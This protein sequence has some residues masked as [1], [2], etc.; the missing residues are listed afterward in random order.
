MMLGKR[1]GKNIAAKGA[2]NTGSLRIPSTKPTGSS[3]GLRSERSAYIQPNTSGYGKIKSKPER[4]VTPSRGDMSPSSPY[5]GKQ[6]RKHSISSY[7]KLDHWTK[8]DRALS[9]RLR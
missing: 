3:A 7:K 8:T 2:V 4:D 5:K 6:N 1:V 9:K